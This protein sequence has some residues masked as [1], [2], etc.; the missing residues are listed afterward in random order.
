MVF[1]LYK[2][3]LVLIMGSLLWIVRE[4]FWKLLKKINRVKIEKKE[5]KCES[6]WKI[7]AL[8][9]YT[10]FWASTPNANVICVRNVLMKLSPIGLRSKSREKLEKFCL[11]LVF[12]FKFHIFPKQLFPYYPFPINPITIPVKSSWLLNLFCI[13]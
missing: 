12:R 9:D 10:R 3:S 5:K 1:C 6:E 13:L 8:L 11:L 7:L 4:K 2:I